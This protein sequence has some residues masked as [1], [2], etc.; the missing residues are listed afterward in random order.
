MFSTNVSENMV[1]FWLTVDFQRTATKKKKKKKK[2]K[3]DAIIAVINP[4]Y[5]T[6]LCNYIFIAQFYL[7]PSQKG[8][9][10]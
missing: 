2:K 7:H 5:S 4:L 8:G 9:L 3:K 1:T 10:F 6:T